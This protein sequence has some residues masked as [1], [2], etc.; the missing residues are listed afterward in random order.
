MPIPTPTKTESKDKFL[1]NNVCVDDSVS[2]DCTIFNSRF[3]VLC[4]QCGKPG[5]LQSDITMRSILSH[6]VECSCGCGC[7]ILGE[8]G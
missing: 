8:D 4:R 6:Y 7:A 3:Q 2:E 1:Y 5:E